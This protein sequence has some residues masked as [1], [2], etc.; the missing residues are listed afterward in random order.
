MSWSLEM[1][2]CGGV[3]EIAQSCMRSPNGEITQLAQAVFWIFIGSEVVRII[4]EG[5]KSNSKEQIKKK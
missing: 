3:E 1:A 2:T 4:G 5:Y